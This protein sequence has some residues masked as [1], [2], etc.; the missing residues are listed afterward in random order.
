M[1]GISTSSA[2]RLHFRKHST[3]RIMPCGNTSSVSAEQ[4]LSKA[5]GNLNGEKH[6]MC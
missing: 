6:Q 5:E 3:A 4:H 1:K 2:P